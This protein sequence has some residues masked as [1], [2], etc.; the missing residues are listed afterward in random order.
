MNRVRS[1]TYGDYNNTMPLACK[2]VNSF[3]FEISTGLVTRYFPLRFLFT[4]FHVI[5]LI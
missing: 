2:S 5:L 1:R 4:I 3:P